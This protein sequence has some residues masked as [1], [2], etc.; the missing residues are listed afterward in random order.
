MLIPSSSR[1]LFGQTGKF[2]PQTTQLPAA[3][4]CATSKFLITRSSKSLSTR[5]R[6]TA[7]AASCSC[8]R[9]ASSAHLRTFVTEQFKLAARAVPTARPPQAQAAYQN[10]IASPMGNSTSWS[11]LGARSVSCVSVLAPVVD[12]CSTHTYPR[13]DAHIHVDT[14]E[15]R[16]ALI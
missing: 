15:K 11:T 2:R 8:A 5:D 14:N 6:T 9:A 10:P 3:T 16:L 7:F 4:R 1:R 12:V 13:A